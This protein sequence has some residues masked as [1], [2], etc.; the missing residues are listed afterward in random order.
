MK[1]DELSVRMKEFYEHR[2]RTYLTR[3]VPVIIR[4]DG[5]AFHTFTRKFK[6]PYDEIFHDAMNNTMKYLCENI[7]G[8]K[9]GY[10]QSDEITL[11]LTDYDTITTDAWFDYNVQKLCSIAASMATLKFNKYLSELTDNYLRS[12]EWV[13]H[14]WEEDVKE[15]A[16]TLKEAIEKGA[17][18][19]ARCFNIPKEEVVNC[20]IW[21]QQDA[22][23]NA[24][25]MLGQTHFSHKQLDKKSQSDIQDMLMTQKGI[26]FNDMPVEFKRG[27]CC[28]RTEKEDIHIDFETKDELRFM[29]SS[30]IIDKDIPIFTQDRSYIERF[31]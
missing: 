20:F 7:Q 29:R 4:L 25:Q 6:K 23:R 28:Y 30:W 12:D 24:V 1:K 31:I 17:M 3:R 14:Y 18:F 2:N 5:K 13:N 10:T 8:C 19:D 16:Y 22:T 27:V 26:N 21:R 11:L 15:Y 9:M